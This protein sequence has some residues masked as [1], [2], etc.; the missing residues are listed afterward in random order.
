MRLAFAD[1]YKWEMYMSRLIAGCLPICLLFV[2]ILAR[3]QN[4][5]PA[6]GASDSGASLETIVVTGSYLRRAD[7]ESPSPVDV[8]SAE[9]I[10]KSGRTTI[11]DVI[12]SLS[13]D[14]SGTLT[15]NFSG[16]MA[17]G[18]SGVS[19]RGLT[20]DATL[21]LIDGHRMATYPLA[22]DG[23]RPFVDISS[24]PLGIVDRVEVLKDGAS[25]IYGSDAIA[26]VV[27]I[28]T[29]KEFTGFDLATNLGSSIKAD[30]LSQRVSATYG[31]GN[32][33]NDGHNV[34]VN[35]EYRHSAE[36]KQE[37]RG[38]YL[39]QLDLRPYGGS[40]L[41][42]GVVQQAFPNNG[43]YTA[44]GQVAPL[45]RANV[46]TDAILPK[47]FMKSIRR[48]GFG[49]HLFDEWRYLDHG[50]L[51][52]DPSKR[53][54]NPDFVLNACRYA[55]ASILLSRRNFGAGSSREHA[56]WALDEYGFRA[57]IAPTFADIFLDNC[58]RNGLAAVTPS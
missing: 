26:G 32:L 3:A 34:Y 7:T 51:G 49:P 6:R 47:Q 33:I 5:G 43:T 37:D 27:N 35:V 50:E 1:P 31:F 30:G 25:A 12:H 36:I 10:L 56:Q 8:I 57:L 18:A 52:M 16:A 53:A 4:V 39:N 44:V 13:S 22:D 11:A 17:G 2:P 48:A 14:N 45:D 29:K 38:S 28:I 19:L 21:V 20:V 23:Q 42:G 9:D 40:D 41:R 15:Q 24:L 55:G 58:M 54:L 46:D